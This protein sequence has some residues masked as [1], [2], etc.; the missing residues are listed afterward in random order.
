MCIRDRVNGAGHGTINDQAGVC[1]TVLDYMVVT[2]SFD[3]LYFD[4]LTALHVFLIITLTH[5]V[6]YLVEIPGLNSAMPL[7]GP[8]IR[9]PG[10]SEYCHAI[11][12]GF[13]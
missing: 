12:N 3:V 13:A 6:T 11:T 5:T 7:E 9:V 8:A 2:D 1:I 4:V 10:F